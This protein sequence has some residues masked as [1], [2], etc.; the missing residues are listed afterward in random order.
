MSFIKKTTLFLLTFCYGASCFSF[1]LNNS[2]S[3][4]FPGKDISINVADLECNHIGMTND[5][6]LSLAIE[7]ANQYWNRVPTSSLSLVRGNLLNVSNQFR[8]EALCTN[9]SSSN[10]EPNNNLKVS[11]DILISCNIN[12][13]NFPSNA[14]LGLTLPNYISGTNILGALILINDQEGNNFA[15]KSHPQQLAI[16]AHEM[17]HA[18]GLGHSPVKDSLMYYQTIENRTKLG[19]DD[20]DGVTYLYPMEQPE[21]GFLNGCG[22]I[23]KIH[24]NQNKP[25]NHLFT[26]ILGFSLFSIFIRVATRRWLLKHVS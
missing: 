25:L 1:T 2:V 16:L 20:I 13:T 15:D 17:G 8:T 24:N 3:A 26:V 22:S 5:E 11:Y 4:S 7:A 10:C 14:L 23:Q 9:N 18:I 6:L 21:I 19:W 12:T